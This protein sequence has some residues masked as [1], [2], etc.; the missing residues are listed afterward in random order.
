MVNKRI[1]ALALVFLFFAILLLFA[2]FKPVYGIFHFLPE[3]FCHSLFGVYSS[4]CDL[5]GNLLVSDDLAKDGSIRDD[6]ICDSLIMDG[7]AGRDSSSNIFFS[8]DV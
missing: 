3:S 4:L 5:A 7:L 6:F 8:G 1:I 2:D